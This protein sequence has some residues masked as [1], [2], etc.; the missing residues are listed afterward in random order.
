[1]KGKELAARIRERLRG[2]REPRATRAAAQRE[3]KVIEEIA[4]EFTTEELTEFLEGDVSPVR[5]DPVFKERLRQELWELVQS[6]YGE[7]GESDRD[8]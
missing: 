8:A 4:A 1:V 2:Q 3:R 6:Q 5:A 7:G